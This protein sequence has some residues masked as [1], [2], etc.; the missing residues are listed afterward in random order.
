[1][2]GM[3][4]DKGWSHS[5]AAAI[6]AG[7]DRESG[8]RSGAVGD[9][10]QAYGAAQWHPDRQAQFDAW[11]KAGGTNDGRDIRHSSIADQTD[12]INWDLTKGKYKSVGDHMRAAKTIEEKTAIFDK[13]YESPADTEGAIRSDIPRAQQWATQT[14]TKPGQSDNIP[15][16]KVR[17]SDRD[18]EEQPSWVDKLDDGPLKR[19]LQGSPRTAAPQNDVR[20]APP[21]EEPLPRPTAGDSKHE[22]VIKVQA[23]PGTQ[24]TT[25]TTGSGPAAVLIHRAMP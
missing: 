6:L 12:F 20:L 18:S 24:T 7:L 5:D 22:V 16:M 21:P 19:L 14:P 11:S 9:N 17:P 4:E 3:F 25:T 8:L 1:M 2:M 10:G 13:E 23:P 15:T